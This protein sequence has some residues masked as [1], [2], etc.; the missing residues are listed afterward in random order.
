MSLSYLG[1]TVCEQFGKVVDTYMSKEW[2]HARRCRVDSIRAQ[3]HEC[4]EQT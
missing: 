4:D 3:E 2:R 1:S